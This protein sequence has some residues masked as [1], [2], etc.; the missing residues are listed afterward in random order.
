VFWL[1]D[2]PPARAPALIAAIDPAR[3]APGNG[4]HLD[5]GLALAAELLG[6]RA[7]G[8]R[9]LIAFTDEQ[10]RPGFDA[11]GAGA[12]LA[13]LPADAIVHLIHLEA[14]AAGPPSL[15]RDDDDDLAAIAARWGGM[16]IS[17]VGG[18][19]ASRATYAAAALELVRP[20]RIDQVVLHRGLAGAEP[21]FPSATEHDV[22]DLR[23]GLGVYVSWRATDAPV[24]IE[25]KIWGRT[26]RRALTS[27]AAASRQWAGLAVADPIR[28]ELAEAD[29]LAL[30]TLGSVVSTMTS[31]LAI[32]SRWPAAGLPDDWSGAMGCSCDTGTM[33]GR[34]ISSSTTCG[35]YGT[36]GADLGPSPAILATVLE[37]RAQ[38]CAAQ[39]HRGA[40]DL[41][42][43]F[44]TTGPEIVDV[45]VLHADG[46]FAACIEDAAWDVVL[47]DRF[48]RFSGHYEARVRGA[49]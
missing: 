26:W 20:L 30:A 40:W 43:S 31:F 12:A 29:V 42:V 5:R 46:A 25:G 37:P 41:A 49:R 35:G 8:P 28:D 4:S 18:G 13:A 22:G 21:S 10:W 27:D 3:L 39:H 15:A 34:S 2:P 36:V 24:S 38:A 1:W 7:G 48:F 23:A 9:R 17:A 14:G 44:D 33:I 47:D 32:D 11:S 19:P 45:S 6:P 16:M